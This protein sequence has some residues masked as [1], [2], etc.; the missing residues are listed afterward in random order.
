V[1]PQPPVTRTSR[2]VPAQLAEARSRRALAFVSGAESPL[3]MLL[4]LLPLR[5]D[6]LPAN[7]MF[8]TTIIILFPAL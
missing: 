2:A 7:I 3:R 1:I 8:I 5:P 4:A 6:P